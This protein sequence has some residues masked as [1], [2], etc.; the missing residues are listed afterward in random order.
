MVRSISELPQWKKIKKKYAYRHL[1]VSKQCLLD[2]LDIIIHWRNLHDM[3]PH[4]L[5]IRLPYVLLE[6]IGNKKSGRIIAPGVSR[7][8]N[9][10]IIVSCYSCSRYRTLLRWQLFIFSLM[11]RKSPWLS[12]IFCALGLIGR[13]C[14]CFILVIPGSRMSRGQNWLRWYYIHRK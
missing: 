14:A 11:K 8:E 10:Y 6:V 1:V 5:Q 13:Q 4:P 2:V 3:C 7:Q 12:F 9:G